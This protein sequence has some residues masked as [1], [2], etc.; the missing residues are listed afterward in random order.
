MHGYKYTVHMVAT[1]DDISVDIYEDNI[2]SLVIDYDYHSEVVIPVVM[3]KLRLDKNLL[4]YII[5][6]KDKARIILKINKVNVLQDAQSEIQYIN[7][8]C[9]YELMD[10]TYNDKSTLYDRDSG[11]EDVYAETIIGLISEDCIERNIKNYDCV[12]KDGN[13]MGAIA[14]FC[15][16]MPLVIEPF[17][18]NKEFDQLIIPPLESI[19]QVI[20][21][22][23]NIAVFYD[24][25]LRF[26]ND[27]HRVYLLSSSGNP[28]P[29]I[30]ELSST[31]VITL[32]KPDRDTDDALTL[33]IAYN[34]EGEYYDMKVVTNDAVYMK[35]NLTDKDFN[36]FVGILDPSREKSLPIMIDNII[37]MA[38]DAVASLNNTIMS[39]VGDISQ[40][41][42]DAIA[43]NHQTSYSSGIIRDTTAAYVE[44]SSLAQERN[45][46]LL[47]KYYQA[48]LK[49]LE[50]QASAQSSSGTGG[51]HSPSSSASASKYLARYTQAK[52]KISGLNSI[53][54]ETEDY[55]Y[56]CAQG[57]VNVTGVAD[58]ACEGA[59]SMV[60]YESLYNGVKIEDIPQNIPTMEAKGPINETYTRLINSRSI[61]AGG[62]MN[63]S[64]NGESES[65]TKCIDSLDYSIETIDYFYDEL[66]KIYASIQA[67]Q[68]GGSQSS[69][70]T[71]LAQ[72]PISESEHREDMEELNGYK[73]QVVN[74]QQVME[75][76]FGSIIECVAKDIGFGENMDNTL[77]SLTPS[78]ESLGEC[79]LQGLAGALSGGGI[80][81]MWDIFS[82][83]LAQLATKTFNEGMAK[84]GISSLEDLSDISKIGDLS[85]IGQIGLTSIIGNKLKILDS[86]GSEKVKYI[87]LGN[88]D[89]NRIKVMENE[90]NLGAVT[91]SCTKE[92]IDNSILTINKEYIV[93]NVDSKSDLNGR[94]LLHHKQEIYVREDAL[95]NSKTILDFVKVPE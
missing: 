67:T 10:D 86:G 35:N 54:E 19:K 55:L 16:H 48:L 36:K 15:A 62:Y 47:D 22:L 80:G 75:E 2:I 21:F 66:K 89:P 37:Q 8:V 56:K 64:H 3:A 85:S 81:A 26:Y 71:G 44:T 34:E 12:L 20:R 42:N 23:Y 50:K 94:Y 92:N 74:Q 9:T 49:A 93:Q 31:V 43:G 63:D 1:V 84:L 32:R 68:G 24:T 69:Q 61:A 38:G 13:F 90:I 40:G 52:N 41:A 73:D 78:V 51:H 30:G 29:V 53:P 17:T 4:D 46:M 82:S 91:F 95:F 27:F 33:G 39:K 59:Y 5:E 45:D 28:V 76:H 87:D 57:K 70:Q 25:P 18:Y 72:C 14:Y 79:L 88:D 60:S 65:T 6:N 7:T 11:R 58:I 83:N 77:E